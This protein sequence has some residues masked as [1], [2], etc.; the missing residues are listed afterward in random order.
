MSIFRIITEDAKDEIS[1]KQEELDKL[2]S[3]FQ[4]LS[5]ELKYKKEDLDYYNKDHKDA[6]PNDP[7]KKKILNDIQDLGSKMTA[8][9][10]KM[11]KLKIQITKLKKENDDK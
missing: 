5:R 6:D 3:E 9:T 8:T 11:A 4:D 1:K 10:M 2:K 7:K